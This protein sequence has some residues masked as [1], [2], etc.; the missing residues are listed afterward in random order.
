MASHQH[1][2]DRTHLSLLMQEIALKIVQEISPPVPQPIFHLHGGLMDAAGH[3]PLSPPL[4]M[5]QT[6]LAPLSLH[7]VPPRR[8]CISYHT[9]QRQMNYT[10]YQNISVPQK[11]LPLRTDA[12]T[13]QCAPVPEV[14]ALD[15]PPP[16]VTMK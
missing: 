8:S 11:A 2:L 13:R 15:V 7:P 5:G 4:A 9:N 16:A 3:W 6:H 14:S 10:S 12:G 1:C